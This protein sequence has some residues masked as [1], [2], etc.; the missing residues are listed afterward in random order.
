MAQFSQRIVVTQTTL[1]SKN[2]VNI[3]TEKTFFKK[4]FFNMARVANI[5]CFFMDWFY[6]DLIIL[7]KERET[8]YRNLDKA[9]LFSRNQVF[10]LKNWKLWR[11]PTPMKFNIFC[12][13]FAHISYLPMS[14]KWCLWSFL[15]CLDFELF[16]KIKKDLVSTQ[17]FFTFLLIIQDL[18][19]IK[20]IPN[21]LL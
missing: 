8:P 14:T 19:K 5:N 10:C 12:W 21:T 1:S 3:Y 6:Y 18:N 17:S 16:A 4:I 13:K 20:K 11:D 15:F 7:I 2:A 9:L